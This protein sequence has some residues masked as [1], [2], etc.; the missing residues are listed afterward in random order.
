MVLT[1]QEN[2]FAQKF[3]IK[4]CTTEDVVNIFWTWIYLFAR[5]LRKCNIM[6]IENKKKQSYVCDRERLW[7]GNDKRTPLK[8][9]ETSDDGLES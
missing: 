7:L 9:E 4:E 3:N 1:F 2:V 5:K 8:V 6:W